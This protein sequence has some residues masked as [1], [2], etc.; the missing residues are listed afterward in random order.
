MLD[1]ITRNALGAFSVAGC[2]Y[3]VVVVAC[4]SRLRAHNFIYTSR[5]SPQRQSPYHQQINHN[6]TTRCQALMPRR[7]SCEPQSFAAGV[8]AVVASFTSGT[9]KPTLYLSQLLHVPLGWR[10]QRRRFIRGGCA[11]ACACRLRMCLCGRR[12]IKAVFWESDGFTL[13]GR[14]NP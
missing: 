13:I 9:R 6:F 8:L 14:K 7:P 2:L 10:R 12:S 5:P 4:Q 3:A 11:C 1:G